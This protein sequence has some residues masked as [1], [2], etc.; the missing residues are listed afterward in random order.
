[1]AADAPLV[2]LV[3]EVPLAPDEVPLVPEV[4][5]PAGGALVPEVPLVPEALPLAE[6]LLV[7]AISPFM[8][9]SGLPVCTALS[10]ASRESAVLTAE[11]DGKLNPTLEVA[12]TSD[13][14]APYCK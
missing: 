6:E 14:I 1:L 8:P 9:P 5:P 2:P 11:V 7:F 10:W 3:P 12:V 13:M 4:L